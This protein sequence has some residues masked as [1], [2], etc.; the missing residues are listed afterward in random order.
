MPTESGVG[1]QMP[2][3]SICFLHLYDEGG[4]GDLLDFPGF[5]NV[6]LF[7]LFVC[8]NEAALT[9]FIKGLCWFLLGCFFPQEDAGALGFHPTNPGSRSGETTL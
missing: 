6:W 3:G 8:F 7:C 1:E 2:L 9:L 4:L 5:K